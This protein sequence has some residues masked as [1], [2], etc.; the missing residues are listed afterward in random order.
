MNC[1]VKETQMKLSRRLPYPED[2][3]L[4]KDG[5]VKCNHTVLSDRR[6]KPAI[7]AEAQ[8]R[9]VVV[10]S[11]GA[12]SER[13]ALGVLADSMTSFYQHLK[14]QQRQG[15]WEKS[16]EVAVFVTGIA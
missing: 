6:I 8:S 13:R 10:E 15:L 9:F 16:H 14:L 4:S 5:D 11:D 12:V 1:I 2:F 3:W 7:V